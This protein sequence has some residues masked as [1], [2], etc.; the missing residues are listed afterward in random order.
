MSDK[1]PARICTVPTFDDSDKA[2]CGGCL[3][4]VLALFVLA[5]LCRTASL[6][7]PTRADAEKPRNVTVCSGCGTEWESFDNKPSKPIT[8]CPNCP[9]SEEEWEALKEQMRKRTEKP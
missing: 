7:P 2:I 1:L 3:L 8:K 9:M 5:S 6:K 4:V